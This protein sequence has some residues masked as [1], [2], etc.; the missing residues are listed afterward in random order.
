M[1][2]I[3]T[4]GWVIGKCKL[5]SNEICSSYYFKTIELKIKNYITHF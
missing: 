4:T 3:N 5:E 1:K 2:V